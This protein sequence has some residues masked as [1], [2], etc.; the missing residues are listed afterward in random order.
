M[1]DHPWGWRF[2]LG[3]ACV[4]AAL[5]FLGTLLAPDSPN[6]L[7]LNGKTEK[8]TEVGLPFGSS[9]SAWHLFMP[10]RLPSQMMSMAL[11]LDL[12]IEGVKSRH[13]T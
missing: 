7:L 9:R 11:G 2:S 6:S 10:C 1:Q 5:F 12:D 13:P 8:A 4:F 3:F